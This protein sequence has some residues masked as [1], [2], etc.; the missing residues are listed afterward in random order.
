MPGGQFS[1]RVPHNWVIG[2][3]GAAK[4]ETHTL[5]LPSIV[6][7]QG[8]GRPPPV[9]GEPGYWVPSGRN[10]VILPPSRPVC[11]DICVV[12]VRSALAPIFKTAISST[13]SNIPRSELPN[14]LET[15]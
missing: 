12:R 10:S 15:Q 3:V 8:P 13:I 1:V 7:T 11:L 5:S 6:A 4:L 2:L 9:N 14:R